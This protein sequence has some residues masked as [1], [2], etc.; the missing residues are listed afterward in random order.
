[1]NWQ[2]AVWLHS[3]LHD[4]DETFCACEGSNEDGG[5]REGMSK[6]RSGTGSRGQRG[7]PKYMIELGNDPAKPSSLAIDRPL[8]TRNFALAYLS[9][10][11]HMLANCQS[12]NLVLSRKNLILK[13]LH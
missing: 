4:G 3:I 5:L 9:D 1:M 7:V 10:P 13:V 2:I 8:P 12:A 11:K 6:P